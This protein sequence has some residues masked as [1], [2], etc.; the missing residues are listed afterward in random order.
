MRRHTP[1]L[2]GRIYWA[3]AVFLEGDELKE[4]IDG[5]KKGLAFWP[6]PFPSTTG[7]STSKSLPGTQQPRPPAKQ[8]ARIKLRPAHFSSLGLLSC[9]GR[10]GKRD[11]NFTLFS[12]FP[13]WSFTLGF[14]FLLG[15]IVVLVLPPPPPPLPPPPRPRPHEE[16][17]D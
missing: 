14:P 13:R 3:F 15:G 16:L 12:F 4:F 9:G 1:R 2:G 17:R 8:Q 10:R 6:H 5:R 7:G 11:G